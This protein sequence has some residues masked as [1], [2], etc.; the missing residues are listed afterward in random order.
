MEIGVSY[1]NLIEL[2][3]NI[4]KSQYY[5]SYKS[6][7]RHRVTEIIFNYDY[8]FKTSAE[9][10]KSLNL[11]QRHKIYGKLSR[12]YQECLQEEENNQHPVLR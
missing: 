8:S 6:N 9:Q 3:C 12:I 11:N 7:I 1:D 10:L 2:V 4:V 5:R